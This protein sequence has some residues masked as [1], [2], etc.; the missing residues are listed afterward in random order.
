MNQVE[1]AAISSSPW[2]EP[3][4]PKAIPI[5]PSCTNVVDSAQLSRMHAEYRRIYTN[6]IN[7]DQAL[8]KLILED[9]KNMYTS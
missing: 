7:V 8:Q 2:V 4:N 1:Y 6:I 9:N 5:I 3:F